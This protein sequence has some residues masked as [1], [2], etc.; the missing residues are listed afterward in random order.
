M[1]QKNIKVLWNKKIKP[2]YYK[3]GLMTYKGYSKAKP[4]QFVM[5]RL[6]NQTVP[7]LNRPFS[8]HNLIISE[9]TKGI[10]ILYK[11]VGGFTKKLSVLKPDDPIDILGPL[12]NNFTISE[13][14]S[15]VF[16][17]AG[18]IGVA[19]IYFLAA[20]LKKIQGLSDIKV[21]LG[22]KS[23]GDLLCLDDFHRI[24]IKPYIST[25]DGSAGEKGLI[26]KML[27][28][29][30][31]T[32]KPELVCACGPNAM[33]QSVAAITDAHAVKCQVSIETIMACGIGAC[34]GCAVESKKKTEKY[35]HTCI[36]GPVFN[37]D[38]IKI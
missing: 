38:T 23:S 18:G 32:N 30:L 17:I 21:F 26:T 2:F 1:L 15:K 37:T 25:D 14:D 12:G 8:I 31:I 5:L 22:G 3:I 6:P 10:E 19:P 7:L 4:G 35:L 29:E 34:L 27:D 28:S 24:G 20:Y 13:K 16:L 11:V 33:L 9:S 36:D